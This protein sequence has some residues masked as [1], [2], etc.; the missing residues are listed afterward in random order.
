MPKDTRKKTIIGYKELYEGP[1]FDIEYQ[2]AQMWVICLITFTFGPML[3]LMFPFACIGM[4]ILYTTIRLRIAYSVRRFPNYD[5]KMNKAMIVCLRA[6][7]IIYCG[8]SA[9]LYSN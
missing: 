3:P 7:P 4:I 1:L 6:C 5:N 8:I 9:W 2:Y